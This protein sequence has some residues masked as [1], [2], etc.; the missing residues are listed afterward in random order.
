VADT[1]L[2][3]R[4]ARWQEK[5]ADLDASIEGVRA[6][7]GR[8][9]GEIGRRIARAGG[10]L[11]AAGVGAVG[12][13]VAVA[14]IGIEGLLI[15]VPVAGAVALAAAL[16][17]T[18][19]KVPPAPKFAELPAARLGASA[20]EWFDLRRVGFPVAAA[21]ATKRILDRLGALGP[22]LAPLSESDPTLSDA[23]RLLS[24]HL[25]RLVDAWAAV[26]V[27]ARAENPEVD[28]GLTSG[29]GVVADELD[30]MFAVLTQDKVR[31][32]AAQG[33]FLETRYGG[34]A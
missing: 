24:D 3:A 34:D 18:R 17:P 8:V 26:P 10:V 20:R 4:H 15:G 31:D 14:P 1:D 25:P 30:R 29:L 9:V 6:H 16:L 2:A 12:Y 23:R 5:L 27:A 21:P 7:S 33:R 32:V 19:R 11:G 22:L 28:A 13:A